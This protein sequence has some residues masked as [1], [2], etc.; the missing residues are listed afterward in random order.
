[1]KGLIFKSVL[2]LVFREQK[3]NVLRLGDNHFPY[4]Q[5]TYVCGTQ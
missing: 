3:Q 5:T 4:N 1:M 2:K